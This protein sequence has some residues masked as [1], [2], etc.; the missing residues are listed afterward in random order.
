MKNN[1]A[2]PRNSVKTSSLC[3]VKSVMLDKS[4]LSLHLK[5]L[6]DRY[7]TLQYPPN[8]AIPPELFS[9]TLYSFL[10]I[11]R[12]NDEISIVVS[13]SD[14]SDHEQEA[15]TCSLKVDGMNEPLERAGPWRC[16]VVH[17]PMDLSRSLT[18]VEGIS[19]IY[20]TDRIQV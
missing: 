8:T 7:Y 3:L 12:V 1:S 18:I 10:S 14:T 20:W 6:S 16:I 13:I 11:T 4:I 17:G 5:I 19:A 15:Q 9:S 2:H